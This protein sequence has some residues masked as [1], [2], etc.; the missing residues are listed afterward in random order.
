M[1]EQKQGKYKSPA[2][3]II[4]GVRDLLKKN[5]RVGYVLETDRLDHKNIL[6]TGASSGLG[7]AT[8]RQLAERGAC[9]YMACRSGIPEKGDEIRKLTGSGQVWMMHV[10]LSDIDSII[11]LVNLI[12]EKDLQFDLVICNAAI[13]PKESRQTKQGLEEMFM[14]NYLAKYTLIRLLIDKHCIRFQAEEKPRFIFVASESHRNP[15]D[16]DWE[17]FGHYQSYGM[18][19]TVE[20]YGYFKLLLT[21]FARELSRRLNTD[22]NPAASVFALCPGPV[23]TRIAREAPALFQP[24]LK[25]IF[26][27]FFKSPEKAAEPVI[28]FATSSEVADRSFDYLHLM[29]RKEIDRKADNM[30]NGKK[31]WGLSEVL[32]DKHGLKFQN[33]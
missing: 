6:I 29:T 13:V 17:G 2:G 24:L 26:A 33:G 3:A 19:K 10:D 16:F 14:V 31:L 11:D 32:L 21:T 4:T 30:E 23:N 7:F 5:V 27:L 8:A 28:Y 15:E 1:E 12:S 9:V 20:R 25:L 22:H 18:G